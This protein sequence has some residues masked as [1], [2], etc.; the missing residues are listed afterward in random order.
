M[1]LVELLCDQAHSSFRLMRNVLEVLETGLAISMASAIAANACLISRFLER[2]VRG[3]TMLAMMF[4]TIHG[5]DDPSSPLF[6]SLTSGTDA[7]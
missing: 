5:A 2:N 7:D 3:S 4:L 1:S 6:R